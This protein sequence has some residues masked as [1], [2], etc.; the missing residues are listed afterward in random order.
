MSSG[1]SRQVQ[2]TVQSQEQAELQVHMTMTVIDAPDFDQLLDIK[3]ALPADCEL[4][5]AGCQVLRGEISAGL[6]DANRQIPGG[7]R[8]ILDR[9]DAS[10]CRIGAMPSIGFAVAAHSCLVAGCG[11]DDIAKRAVGGHGWQVVASSCESM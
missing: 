9:L 11:I 6:M 8:V 10:G 3:R 4:S 5:D 7:R 1:M 2:I